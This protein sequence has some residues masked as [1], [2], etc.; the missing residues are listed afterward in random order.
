MEN[1]DSPMFSDI[2]EYSDVQS[3]SS[4]DSDVP[5]PP[6]RTPR[7][8]K[9]ADRRDDNLKRFWHQGDEFIETKNLAA[10]EEEAQIIAEALGN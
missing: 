2:N 8:P 3:I 4:S 1:D 10:E 7:T 5:Q 6:P 9:T